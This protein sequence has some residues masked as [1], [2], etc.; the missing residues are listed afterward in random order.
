M[1]DSEISTI[2][3]LYHF[4]SFK[5]FK[6]FH[7]FYIGVHLCA[8]FPKQLF[9]SCFIVI[10]H[11]VLVS[12]MLFLNIVC[13]GECTGV[14]FVDSTKIS[15]CYNKRIFSKLS[16]GLPNA[17]KTQWAGSTASN[18]ILFAIRRARYSTFIYLPATLTIVT[19]EFLKFSKRSFSA[20]FMP[21]KGMFSKTCLECCSAKAYTLLPD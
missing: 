15:V 9:Y 11:K 13:F 12:T 4:G 21:T 3:I 7:L 10:E 17:E 18:Y 6:H 19:H 16:M 1:S 20:N 8:E 2:L 14:N 5:N